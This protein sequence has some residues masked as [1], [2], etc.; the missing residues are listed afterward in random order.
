MRTYNSIQPR[1][2]IVD[3][4]KERQGYEYRPK[5]QKWLAKLCWFIL[6]KLK[7]VHPHF[8]EVIRYTFHEYQQEKL[9]KLVFE[10]LR[11]RNFRDHENID[12]YAFLI[13]RE[14]FVALV[15]EDENILTQFIKLGP[16]PAGPLGYEG[17]IFGIMVHVVNNLSG[18][19]IVPKVA[20]EKKV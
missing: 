15:R 5:R 1:E 13:G 16:F 20:I 14:D 2:C 12:D 17:Q 19:A 3:I 10:C 6:N 18:F 9:T 11:E 8:G 4:L 7:A